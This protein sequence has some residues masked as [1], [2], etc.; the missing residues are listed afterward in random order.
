MNEND[1]SQ[2]KNE[3]EAMKKQAFDSCD[4]GRCESEEPQESF[5]DYPDYVR[6][7]YAEVMPPIKSGIYFSRWDIKGMAAELDEHIVV[8]VRE[9]MF[10]HFMR[11]IV[12][13]E[14]ME[15]VVEQFK[16][17]IDMK[18]NLYKEYMKK[19]PATQELFS[20]KIT[21][22]SRAKEF[23]DKMIVDFFS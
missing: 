4:D 18:C 8:D 5:D 15:N 2:F 7:I 1:I 13:K 22:A 16:K 12:T 23:L 9:R 10:Q 20:S 17:H 19:Y 11:F 21:K 6:A 3:F 14:D